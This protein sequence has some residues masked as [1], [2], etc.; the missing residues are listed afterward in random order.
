MNER[1]LFERTKTV[2]LTFNVFIKA[3]FVAA[4][5]QLPIELDS[6]YKRVSIENQSSELIE[7][8]NGFVYFGSYS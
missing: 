5:L 2:A 7:I 6:E 3:S 4:F 1:N 8:N